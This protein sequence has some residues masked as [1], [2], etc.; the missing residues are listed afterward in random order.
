MYARAAGGRALIVSENLA[1]LHD[2]RLGQDVEITAPFGVV[3]LPVAGIVSD[4]TDQQGT[5][6]IDRTVFVQF[7]RDDSVSDFR[8]FAAAGADVVAVRQ[9]IIDRFA[10]TRHVFVMTN[11]EARAYIL[12]VA[13]RWFELVNVQIAIAVLVA[14]LGIVNALTVSITDRRREL[15]VLKAVGAVRGQIRRTIWLEAMSVAAIGC[16]LGALLGGIALRYLLQIVQRD[17]IGI[18]LDYEFPFATMAV[19][20]PM[21]FVAALVAALWPSESAVRSSLVEALEYE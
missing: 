18:R 3:R 16:I 10:G 5:V 12:Q 7:W 15:G 2:L 13:D 8:V 11:Q 19:I 17:A 21:M 4:Y 6:F 14:M 1:Q 20:V 9:R